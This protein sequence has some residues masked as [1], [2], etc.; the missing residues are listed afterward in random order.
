[1]RI[2]TSRLRGVQ[3]VVFGRKSWRGPDLA[4]RLKTK[5]VTLWSWLNR[6]GL[7]VKVAESLATEL[8]RRGQELMSAAEGLRDEA[9]A[10][11]NA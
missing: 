6:N 10:V 9:K 2:P 3:D 11:L 7:P 8:E 1:M 4:L 5:H